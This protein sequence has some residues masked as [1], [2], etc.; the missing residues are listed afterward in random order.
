MYPLRNRDEAD[1]VGVLPA[2]LSHAAPPSPLPPPPPPPSAPAVPRPTPGKGGAKD[3]ARKKS[4]FTETPRFLCPDEYR[5][6][7]KFR[8]RFAT[9][10]LSLELVGSLVSV[11]GLCIGFLGCF[12]CIV[13]AA[14]LV[15]AACRGVRRSLRLYLLLAY[16]AVA[17]SAADILM[18]SIIIYDK[19]ATSCATSP[20]N[21][22]EQRQ[23]G[24]PIDIPPPTPAICM[25]V[26][27]VLEWWPFSVGLMYACAVF[28]L[29]LLAVRIAVIVRLR[30]LVH[31]V[32]KTMKQ[33]YTEDAGYRLVEMRTS[34]DTCTEKSDLVSAKKNVGAQPTPIHRMPQLGVANREAP[35]SNKAASVIQAHAHGFVARRL[36]SRRRLHETRARAALQA[37]SIPMMQTV[38]KKARAGLADHDLPPSVHLCEALLLIDMSAQQIQLTCRRFLALSELNKRRKLLSQ[39]QTSHQLKRSDRVVILLKK[40][41]KLG[42]DLPQVRQYRHIS[43]LSDASSESRAA[44]LVLSHSRLSSAIQSALE[45]RKQAE[46]WAALAMATELQIGPSERDLYPLVEDCRAVLK[47]VDESSAIASAQMHTA[48]SRKPPGPSPR[49]PAV[50]DDKA[51][52]AASRAAVARDAQRRPL[53]SCDAELRLP[54]ECPSVSAKPS[55][56]AKYDESARAL[57]ANPVTVAHVAAASRSE[58][59][60]N[61]NGLEAAVLQRRFEQKHAAL[62]TQPAAHRGNKPSSEPLTRSAESLPVPA[63][64]STP[65]PSSEKPATPT[66]LSA[67]ADKRKQT[68]QKILAA[69]EGDALVDSL[70]DVE[71][72]GQ[73]T[74]PPKMR[75]EENHSAETAALINSLDFFDDDLGVESWE[76]G[77][78]DRRLQ[79][80]EAM[81]AGAKQLP[82][83]GSRE[84]SQARESG[85]NQSKPSLLMVG[86]APVRQTAQARDA[87]QFIRPCMDTNSNNN[88]WN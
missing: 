85:P 78:I 3:S 35:D 69:E 51:T 84:H 59:V 2:A 7:V 64:C 6:F 37:R 42:I 21:I 18:C 8:G 1:L 33:I 49:A 56:L 27:R 57:A 9:L 73:T 20:P 86:L 62:L 32:P 79:L 50:V 25:H 13:A 80:E 46:L 74:L 77:D 36:V 68:L 4:P 82:L 72:A 44:K 65:P 23:A 34:T 76:S 81:Q 67:V 48:D 31:T 87:H 24:L 58:A 53:G 71:S 26:I 88:V 19:Y 39:L 11:G 45:T 75:V 38:C 70:W 14:S 15:C 28:A 83:Q 16:G 47:E 61:A 54:S 12:A 66:L 10:H 30:K 55:E 43:G 40:A 5:D 52:L 29:L 17:F 63:A 60:A 22:Q 41:E